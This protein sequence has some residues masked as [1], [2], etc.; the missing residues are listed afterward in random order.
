MNRWVLFGGSLVLV[1][2][3]ALV[4]GLRAQRAE[5]VATEA[6]AAAAAAAAEAAPPR[7]IVT[8]D[9]GALLAPEP[10]AAATGRLA[11][12]PPNQL[13]LTDLSHTRMQGAVQVLVLADGSELI[14]TDQLLSSL[15]AALQYRLTYDRGGAR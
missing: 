9:G 11:D 15:P 14:V 10:E 5:A 3:L 8:V 6:T 12:L 7:L 1:S 13:E 4:L 2:G